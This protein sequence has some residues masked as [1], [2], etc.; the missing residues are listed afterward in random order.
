MRYCPLLLVLLT[1]VSTTFLGLSPATAGEL[2][3][4]EARKIWDQAPHNAFTDL[5]RFN[6]QWFCVFREGQGHVSPDGAIRVLTSEDGE[7]W[8]SAAK[9]TSDTSDLRDAK[10][11]ITPDGRLMLI[12]AGALHDPDPVRHQTYVWFSDDGH[13]WSEPQPIGDPNF[14][15][16]RVGWH[17]DMAYGVGYATGKDA[18]R[19]TRLYRSKDGE[20]FDTLV[21]TLFD[22]G[23][24][25]EVGLVFD[26]DDTA[27]CL[28]R[29]DASQPSAQ[30][31]TAQPPYESWTW[32]DLGVRAGG[33]QMIRLDDGR[34]LAT[35]RLYDGKVRT[36][37]CEV[38]PEKGT[39][40]EK[41]TLPSGGDTSYAGMVQQ[42]DILWISYYS[43]HEGKTNIYLAKVAVK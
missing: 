32:K 8:T 4:I 13:E 3:L 9:L 11:S 27:W 22:E 36:S 40:T 34:L 23:Y 25:N 24:P 17:N 2:E 26:E 18:P 41:L 37:V 20:Q 43:S 19:L 5:I 21:E 39:L 42:G 7:T 15:L 35:V 1:A 38:D 10:V 6:D 16:W 33:P 30:L 28:L 14:W 29:R 31:G 12:A